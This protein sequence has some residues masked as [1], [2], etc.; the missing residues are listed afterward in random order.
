VGPGIETRV[1]ALSESGGAGRCASPEP[2]GPC[3]AHWPWR[4]GP[5]GRVSRVRARA[6]HR[7]VGPGRGPSDR[8]GPALRRFGGTAHAIRKAPK[9][10][11]A[12]LQITIATLQSYNCKLCVSVP[13]GCVAKHW[14]NGLRGNVSWG[15]GSNGDGL[16][17]IGPSN[18]ER[19]RGRQQPKAQKKNIYI[20]IIYIYIYILIL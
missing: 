17:R 5:P 1:A 14:Y 3:R 20:F 11:N 13:Q 2:L 7:W 8:S 10:R 9:K 15:V 4:A 6:S 16:R 12:K 19:G 18:H